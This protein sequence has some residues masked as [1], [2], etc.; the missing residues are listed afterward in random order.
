VVRGNE[1]TVR[2]DDLSETG[3]QFSADMR[4]EPGDEF[5]VSAPVDGAPMSVEAQAVTVKP[6]AYG[7]SSIGA[8][9]THI[10]HAD[11]LAL[12]RLAGQAEVSDRPE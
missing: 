8:R 4:I 6:G 9:I 1:C 5:S 7:R 11:L 3:I 2:V 12:R 10:G